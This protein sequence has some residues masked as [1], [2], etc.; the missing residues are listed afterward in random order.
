MATTRHY[1]KHPIY[2]TEARDRKEGKSEIIKE[3]K[4]KKKKN[5][6]TTQWE[7]EWRRKSFASRSMANDWRG[8]DTKTTVD[9]MGTS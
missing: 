9:V 7:S 6:S 2:A 3:D 5:L 8:P 1:K 4:K